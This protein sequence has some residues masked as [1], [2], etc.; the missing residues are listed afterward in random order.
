[1]M[2]KSVAS[3][4]GKGSNGFTL[5]EILIAMAIAAIGM[6]ALA[7]L[8]C[9]AIKGNTMSGRYTQATFLAQN[10]VERL[11]S[12]HMVN[13]GVFGFTEMPESGSGLIQDGG[14]FSGITESGGIGGPFNIQWQVTG[15]TEWSR[16]VAVTVSWKSILGR[17]R[18]LHLV[19]SSRGDGR[20][21]CERRKGGLCYWVDVPICL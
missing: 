8:Q 4:A 3:S 18:Y 1:M 19:S 20:F 14:A 16:R 2:E 7:H 21:Q 5:V 15:H 10:T 11:K 12:G 13:E 9:T 6:F 17:M